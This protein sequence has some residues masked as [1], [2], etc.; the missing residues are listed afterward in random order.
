MGA[1]PPPEQPGGPASFPA[2]GIV[3][4]MP[5]LG[6]H[7]STAGGAYRAFARGKETGCNAMQIFVKSPNQWRAKPLTEEAIIAFREAR[8]AAPQPVVA[9]AAYLIN[10]AS[11]DEEVRARSKAAL[12]DELERCTA[13]GVDALVVHPGAHLGDGVEVGVERAARAAAEVLAEGEGITARLLLENTAGQG[14]TLGASLEE[15][16]SLLDLIDG[17]ERVGVCFDSCHAFAAGYDLRS[18]EA[19]ERTIQELLS[20]IGGEHLGVIHLNDSRFELGARKDRHANVGAGEI[21]EAF[22]ARII[23]DERFAGVPMIVE[24]PLGDDGLGHQ[25]DLKVLRALPRPT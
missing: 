16:E 14:T 21:G 12:L 24:T 9:H 2:A 22:F 15:L 8:E 19:Y 6:A 20:L 23:H 13:L 25:R 7:V 3:P 11:K 5:N 10:L 1:V 4:G 18:E 17:G